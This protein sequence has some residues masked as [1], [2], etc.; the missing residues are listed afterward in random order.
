MALS[1]AAMVPSC[2][3]FT[4]DV[5]QWRG[6][7]SLLPGSVNILE[8]SVSPGTLYLNNIIRYMDIY[9]HCHINLK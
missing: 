3:L 8:H 1:T 9:M 6:A 7:H 2:A 5:P 4:V